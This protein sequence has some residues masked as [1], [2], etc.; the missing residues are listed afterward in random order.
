MIEIDGG[1]SIEA[2]NAGLFISPGYGTH[3]TRVLDSYE[4]IFVTDGELRMYEADARFTVGSNETLLLS[5][6]LRHGGT[7]PYPADVRFYWMHFRVRKFGET[8]P[9]N[10]IPKQ[11]QIGDPEELTDLFCRFISE[12]ESGTLDACSGSHLVAVML[13]II[14]ERRDRRQ[15]HGRRVGRHSEAKMLEAQVQSF[16]DERFREPVSTS[17]IAREL[18]YNPDYLERIYRRENGMSIGEA[19]HQKR[20]GTARMA[21]RN[22]PSKNVNEIAYD[23]G[24][25]QPAYFHRMFKRLSGLTPREFRNLY[26]RTH[27]NSH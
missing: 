22:E 25:R 11:A 15:V 14:A 17:A 6:N 19:I 21:L 10:Q 23:C 18:K 27:I 1:G 12:Q 3:P 5:P 9:A 2:L 13:Y 7:G 26:A 20:I 4:I 16:I 8:T 24:Y